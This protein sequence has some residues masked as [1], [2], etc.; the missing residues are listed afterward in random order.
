MASLRGAVVGARGASSWTH[1]P[2]DLAFARS[3]VPPHSRRDDER[4]QASREGDGHVRPATRTNRPTNAISNRARSAQ[5]RLDSVDLLDPKIPSQSSN[6]CADSPGSCGEEH[7]SDRQT[8]E[9]ASRGLDWRNVADG[10]RAHH[11]QPQARKGGGTRRSRIRW[12]L[13][14]WKAEEKQEQRKREKRSHV[15]GHA[16]TLN[17]R[18]NGRQAGANAPRI[19]CVKNKPGNIAAKVNHTISICTKGRTSVASCSN[20]ITMFPTAA[21]TAKL[22]IPFKKANPIT[23]GIININ[24]PTSRM[25]SLKLTAWTRK[26]QKRIAAC[27]SVLALTAMGRQANQASSGER[28]P[29]AANPICDGNSRATT[30][31]AARMGSPTIQ[32]QRDSSM[33]II[34]SQGRFAFRI[35]PRAHRSMSGRKN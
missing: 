30:A 8:P 7:Y 26:T 19:I 16:Q 32:I 29:R 31:M 23:S 6:S 25:A 14:D 18:G 11:A 15:V 9:V 28:D 1:H 22:A 13:W 20:P 27:A 2:G 12:Q 21:T 10:A 33:I 34:S 4:K 17:G 3:P 24:R 35:L 5:R